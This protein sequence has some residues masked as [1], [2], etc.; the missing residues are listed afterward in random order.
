M[1]NTVFASLIADQRNCSLRGNSRR[2]YSGFTMI[3]L[4]VI[5]VLIG[6]V[7]AM[8]IPRFFDRSTFDS[9]GLYDQ[10]VSTLRYAQKAAV[11]QR[12]LVC[13]TFPTNNSV[14]LNVASVSGAAACDL[15]LQIPGGTP[16][17]PSGVSMSGYAN[18][19][20]SALGSTTTAV[21]TIT[22]GSYTISVEQE[23]GYV[24]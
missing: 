24:H 18:F 22:I 2:I 7:S 13:V 14:Q 9:R 6:I 1:K 17:W 21:N 4:V 3:E 10:V 12:R 20:F 11:A 16:G 5:I 19:N 15:P 23:T 8:A